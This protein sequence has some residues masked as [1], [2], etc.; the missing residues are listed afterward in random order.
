MEPASFTIGV[1][2]LPGQLT[3]VAM[4][5]YKIFDNMGDVGSTYDATLHE[6]RMQGLRLRRW[7]QAW[8]F[9]GDDNQEH[10]LQ[11]E[12]YRYR[13]ATASL[14]TIV[15]VFSSAEKLQ[16]RYGIVV[17]KKSLSVKTGRDERK[18]R[19]RDRLLV[20]IRGWFQSKSPDQSTSRTQTSTPGPTSDNLHVLEN[21]HVLADTRI[22]PDLDDE[23]KSMAQAT[24]RVQ[25][26]LSVYLKLRWVISDNAKLEEL[27][28]NLTSL[29]NGL[30]QVLPAP[31]C[32]LAYPAKLH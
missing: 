1:V 3:K 13:Y 21:P 20:P 24:N 26:S 27:L 12:D 23:I 11:P 10:R 31:E 16:E 17:K 25:Q 22:L 9:G 32:P 8:G 30:F 2:G 19:F 6:L 4:D 29:N 5:C 18:L 28:R 14:A 15:A 7:E